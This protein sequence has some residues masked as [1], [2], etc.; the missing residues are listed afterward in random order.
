VDEGRLSSRYCSDMPVLE[1]KAKEN[2]DVIIFI[3]PY[4]N[5]ITGISTY[6][7]NK[8][9]KLKRLLEMRPLKLAAGHSLLVRVDCEIAM[10]DDAPP[11]TVRLHTPVEGVAALMEEGSFFTFQAR[12]KEPVYR[13]P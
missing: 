11:C 5:L 4:S 7:N 9:K 10:E 1:I 13:K 6:S 12:G 2:K 8:M 3:A